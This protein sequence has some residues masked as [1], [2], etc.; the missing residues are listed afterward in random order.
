MNR[1][2]AI[3]LALSGLFLLS[4]CGPVVSIASNTFPDVPNGFAQEV[5]LFSAEPLAVWV[6]GKTILAVVTV[7]SGSCPPVPIS[8]NSSDASTIDITFVKSPNSPCS[9]DLTPTTH[10]F[11]IPEG[12]DVDSEVTVN[13]LFDFDSDSDYEYALIVGTT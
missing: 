9:A 2:P 12:V 8:I 3:A 7:G 10:E 6:H 11:K 5:N 4:G 1:T 13:V